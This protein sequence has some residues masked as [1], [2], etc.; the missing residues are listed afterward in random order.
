MGS[1]TSW[2]RTASGD[3]ASER[4]TSIFCELCNLSVSDD[5]VTFNADSVIAERKRPDD[6]YQGVRVELNAL[7]AGARL[8]IQVDIGFGDVVTP[9]ARFISYPSLLDFPEPKLRAYTPETVVA[10][11]LEALVSLGIRNSRRKDFFDLWVMAQTFAFDGAILAE[12]IRATFA[13]RRTPI[14]VETPVA[15]MP[16]FAND[17][18]KQSQWRA[19]LKRTR[20]V[21]APEP[22]PDVLAFVAGF[23][24]PV[25][26]AVRDGSPFAKKWS[27]GDA[28][29]W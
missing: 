15:F 27:A 29:S 6:E 22:L 1:T 11:K 17:A 21:M 13:R 2:T 26:V 19:F 25:L 23:A 8:L 20:L 9:E 24:M 4:L 28:W 16:D 18:S 3:P 7:L 14:A 10:E 5:G 12:A